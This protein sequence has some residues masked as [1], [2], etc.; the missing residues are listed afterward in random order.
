M[1]SPHD[2]LFKYVFRQPEHA[3]AELRAIFPPA[4]SE[5]LDWG[6]LALEPSSFVDEELRGHH[7]DVLFSVR[8]AGLPAYVY[9][10]FEH[11]STSDPLMAFR[12]LRYLVR[13]WDDVLSKHPDSKRLPAIVPVVLYQ[14]KSKWAAAT[15]LRQL[16]DLD[17]QTM[18]RIDPYHAQLSFLV[19]DL[20]QTDDRALRSR[21]L[22]PQAAA[23]LAVLARAWNMDALMEVL[24][25]WA[26][27]LAEMGRH[28][29][30]LQALTAFW[31]YALL[32]GRMDRKELRELARS[33]GPIGSEAYMTAAEIL[34]AEGK[35]EGKAEVVLHLLRL[36]FGEVPEAVRG[37]MMRA[38][39]DELDRFAASVL[40]AAS[41][42][43]VIGAVPEE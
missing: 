11:Q 43:E 1:A 36:K 7:A 21:A 13:I 18:A 26:D 30:G 29:D 33:I 42:D 32:V 9:V 6:S 37:R 15:E 20:S 8:C 27:I 39:S 10:L 16:I 2:A 31:T 5:H 12:L 34:H 40:T 28:P 14:G 3:A 19:D 41:L 4:L 25:R 23:A 22:T 24:R 38:D 17:A 35:A